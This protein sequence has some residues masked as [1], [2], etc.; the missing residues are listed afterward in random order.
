MCYASF[1][2]ADTTRRVAPTN[3]E[4]ADAITMTH[5]GVSRIRSGGRLPSIDT[6]RRIQDVYGWSVQ[7]QIEARARGEYVEEFE[8]A[9]IGGK[10]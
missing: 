5:S 8:L 4:V 2:T 10:K 6:M 1:M 9:L 7:D 3:Q